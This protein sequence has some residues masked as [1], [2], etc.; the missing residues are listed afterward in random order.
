VSSLLKNV[1]LLVPRL[2][3]RYNEDSA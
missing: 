2:C 1:R 3:P